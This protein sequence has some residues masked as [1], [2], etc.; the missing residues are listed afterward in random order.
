MNCLVRADLIVGNGPFQCQQ[1]KMPWVVHGPLYGD[2]TLGLQLKLDLKQFGQ[3]HDKVDTQ[4][5]KSAYNWQFN[6]GFG[7]LSPPNRIHK[8]KYAAIGSAPNF[9]TSLS[10][11]RVWPSN[12]SYNSNSPILTLFN[13]SGLLHYALLFGTKH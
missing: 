12:Y 5:Q 3:L 11:W 2:L 9:N 6:P 4:L 1:R 8:R 13:R 7:H 10:T